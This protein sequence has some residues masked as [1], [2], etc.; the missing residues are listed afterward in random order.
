MTQTKKWG[1]AVDFLISIIAIVIMTIMYPLLPSYFLLIYVYIV[2]AFLLVLTLP[3][4][5]ISILS[6][7]FEDYTKAC[8]GLPSGGRLIGY[9]ERSFIFLAFLIAYLENI[10]TFS[11]IFSYLTFIIAGKAIFRF[12]SKESGENA[13]AC[14]DW[15]I[16]GTFLSILLG[17]FL[18]WIVF[19]VPW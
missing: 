14:A 7:K 8:T 4:F 19:R 15:Y 13:R 11:A 5:I 6:I 9:T 10:Q 3:S 12:S 2:G 18:S 16:L 1:K 17:L